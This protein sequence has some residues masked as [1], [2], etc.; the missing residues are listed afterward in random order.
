MDENFLVDWYEEEY[1]L[2]RMQAAHCRAMDDTT[3]MRRAIRL[4][5]KWRRAIRLARL[6]D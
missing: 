1:T 4:A 2:E 5:W 3:G 6:E